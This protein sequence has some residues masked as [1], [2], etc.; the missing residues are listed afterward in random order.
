MQI[1]ITT[2]CIHD[3]GKLLLSKCKSKSILWIHISTHKKTSGKVAQFSQVWT[4][5]P[6]STQS[7]CRSFIMTRTAD[8]ETVG[9]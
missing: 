5:R 6:N 3:I 1:E 9:F 8:L 4:M 7:D 2:C